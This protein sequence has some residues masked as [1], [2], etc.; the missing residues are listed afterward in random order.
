MKIGVCSLTIGTEYKD[1][2]KYGRQSKIEYCE[3]NNYTFIED[4]EVYDITRP[5]PWSKILL[6]KKYLP[7]YDYILWLDG[8]TMILNYETKVE[9]MI[10]EYMNNKDFLMTRDS[11]NLINTGVWFIKNTYYS[12]NILKTIYNHIDYINDPYWEQGA[13]SD[14]YSKNIFDLQS[15]CTILEQKMRNIF[16]ATIYEYK[17]GFFLIHLMGIRGLNHIKEVM[18]DHYFYVREGEDTITYENRKKWFKLR[19]S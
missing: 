2:T 8:D 12:M 3:K 15:N 9:L 18:N 11:G 1:A 10:E 7:F 13:F 5:I 4:S 16:N 17:I 19:Y 14:L 6:I